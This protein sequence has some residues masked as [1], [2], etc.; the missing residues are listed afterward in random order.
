MQEVKT[1]KG[2]IFAI[3]NYGDEHAQKLAQDI[4][5]VPSAPDFLSPIINVIPLQ[6]LAYYVA[7]LKG[8]DVDKPRN[9][10]K[11]VTVE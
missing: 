9:L 8:I 10:A 7:D 3:V 2:R 1:R 4:I 6:L 11:S 5:E